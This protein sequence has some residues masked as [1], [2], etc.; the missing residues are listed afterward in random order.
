M[1]FVNREFRLIFIF[2]TLHV[3]KIVK[4][5]IKV[6]RIVAKT[7][8]KRIE[9]SVT[10]SPYKKKLREAP[11][12]KLT[13]LNCK[14]KKKKTSVNKEKAKVNKLSGK[15]RTPKA[16]IIS[17]SLVEDCKCFICGQ[18]WHDS[19]PGEDWVQCSQCKLWLHAVCVSTAFP[20]LCDFCDE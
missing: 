15:R 7:K 10:D 9:E 2:L 14:S 13:K 17:N 3:K 4:K 20:T 11:E 8:S 18:W 12:R 19:L 16:I 6:P 1:I 5:I